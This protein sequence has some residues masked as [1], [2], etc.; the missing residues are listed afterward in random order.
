MVNV[1]VGVNVGV[2]CPYLV[3]VIVPKKLNQRLVQQLW[4]NQLHIHIPYSEPSIGYSEIPSKSRITTAICA[5]FAASATR[6]KSRKNGAVAVGPPFCV[7]DSSSGCIWVWVWDWD[8]NWGWI[9]DCDGLAPTL[10]FVGM[11]AVTVA[12]AVELKLVFWDCAGTS[13]CT[14]ARNVESGWKAAFVKDDERGWLIWLKGICSMPC[15]CVCS[16]VV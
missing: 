15:V 11:L 5:R 1:G 7:S 3:I 4:V 8:C 10:G 9:W 6:L 12:V 14:C 2:K 16:S 13:P